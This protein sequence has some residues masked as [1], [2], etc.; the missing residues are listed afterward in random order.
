MEVPLYS[1][2]CVD[3]IFVRIML[4]STVPEQRAGSRAWAVTASASG[5]SRGRVVGFISS[6]QVRRVSP[7]AVTG[8]PA[9]RPAS[10]SSDSGT[11]LALINPWIINCAASHPR[12]MLT[13]LAALASFCAASP[14]SKPSN[15]RSTALSRPTPRSG[16][17]RNASHAGDHGD[18]LRTAPAP[19][20]PPSFPQH[21]ASHLFVP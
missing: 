20:P 12:S 19:A 5:W 4:H 1:Y 11:R 10:P 9:G 17:T 14:P 16:G 2:L 13:R 8:R 21:P 18:Q 6:T 15:H 3:F 7:P